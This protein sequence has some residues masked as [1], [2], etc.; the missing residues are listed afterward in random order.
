MVIALK[1]S[2]LKKEKSNKA[3]IVSRNDEGT[4]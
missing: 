3:A 1:P 2:V 4:F